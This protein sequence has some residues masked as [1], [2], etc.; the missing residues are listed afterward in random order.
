[1]VKVGL[2]RLAQVVRRPL[3]GWRLGESFPIPVSTREPPID[4]G[5][6]WDLGPGRDASGLIS[7]PCDVSEDCRWGR[8]MHVWSPF[9]G[10][11]C[12]VDVGCDVEANSGCP[13]ESVCLPTGCLPGVYPPAS[14]GRMCGSDGGCPPH[15]VCRSHPL[16]PDRPYCGAAL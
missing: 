16:Y 8:C 4:L 14:C 5:L 2:R 15:F 10:G 12:A 3:D 1:M 7:G 6:P 13:P 11:V 9:D